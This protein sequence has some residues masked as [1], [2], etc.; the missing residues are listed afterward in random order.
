MLQLHR[1][2][3]SDTH[4]HIHTRTH[5]HTHTH[6]HIHTHIHTHSHTQTSLFIH[7]HTQSRRLEIRMRAGIKSATAAAATGGAPS[8][9]PAKNEHVHLLNSTLTA[10]SRTLCCL[11][12]NYQTPDGLRYE[13]WEDMCGVVGETCGG[14]HVVAFQLLILLFFLLQKPPVFS[15][16]FPTC[17]FPTPCNTHPFHPHHAHQDPRGTAAIHD[18]HDLHPL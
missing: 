17:F 7:T 3:G 5:I 15:I 6:T 10:T 14:G 1:L 8:T 16:P 12:E 18:G 11:L 13:G 9:G 4:T 2:P